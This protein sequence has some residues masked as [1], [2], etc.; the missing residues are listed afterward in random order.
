MSETMA[1]EASGLEKA[2]GGTKA[3][4]GVDFEVPR[5]SILGM[6]G[7]NGAGKTT[8]VRVLATLL[9]PDRGSARVAG[10][11]VVTEAAQ[12]RKHIGLTGQ[13]AALDESLTGRANLVMIGRLGRL[14]VKAAKTRADEL[15]R[16]FSL[17][18]AADR[19]VKTYSG[20]MRRRLDLAA[21]LVTRPQILFLDEPTT[22]LDLSSRMVTWDAVRA[23]ANDGTTVLL[24]SQYLDEADHL[25]DQ[26]VV[27]DHGQVIADGTPAQLKAKVGGERVKLTVAEQSDT[28]RAADVLAKHATDSPQCDPVTREVEAPVTAAA[29][30]MPE[31]VRDLDAAGVLLD[32]LAIRHPSLDDVFLTLTGRKSEQTPQEGDRS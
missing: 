32:D 5:G 3:L 28:A 4:D 21:S 27:I 9:R 8:M 1:L 20:G 14:P 7:P 26:I 31:I 12:V 10:H 30:R 22:G 15:L 16:Q 29:R 6:L 23:L 25:A 17:T 11:D 19:G 18:D 13:Y 24:T 2:F